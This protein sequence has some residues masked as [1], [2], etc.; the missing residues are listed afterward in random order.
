MV[1]DKTMVAGLLDVHLNAVGTEVDGV[2]KGGQ[3]VFGGKIGR[4]AVCN[5]LRQG[6]HHRSQ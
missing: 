4:P 1:D 2:A 5:D 3:G 6:L